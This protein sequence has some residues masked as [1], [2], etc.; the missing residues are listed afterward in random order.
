MRDMLDSFIQ[1]H[2]DC[3]NIES[4]HYEHVNYD[5]DLRLS[6]RLRNNE[7]IDVQFRYDEYRM[8]GGPDA[9]MRWLEIVEQ[10]IMRRN[11]RGWDGSLRRPRDDMYDAMRYTRGMDFAAPQKDSKAD[12]KAKKLFK[13]ACGDEA[14]QL[15]DS[16]QPLPITGSK[17]TAYRLHKKASY[18]VERV[19]D[20]AKLCAVVPGVPLW[21][22]LLG[23][24]LMVENDEKQF[25]KTANVSGGNSNRSIF[26]VFR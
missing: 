15:L 5:M 19:S 16:G 24:K 7:V 10:D 3:R 9:L 22:H 13:L 21:D 11:F 8:G 17:G 1:H 18:C 12:K 23:I 26:N 2:R 6:L 25:L 4:A 20:G 14:L